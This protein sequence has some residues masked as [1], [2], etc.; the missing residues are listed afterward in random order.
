MGK[1]CLQLIAKNFNH[2]EWIEYISHHIVSAET[3]SSSRSLVYKLY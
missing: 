1:T 2:I 3:L